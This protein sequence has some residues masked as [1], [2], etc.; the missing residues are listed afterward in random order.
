MVAGHDLRGILVALIV[1]GASVG[2]QLVTPSQRADASTAPHSALGRA[3]VWAE[4]DETFAKSAF[5]IKSYNWSGLVDTGSTFTSVSGAWIVPTVK[6]SQPEEAAGEWVG[7]G[8]TTYA[9]LIQAGT[10]QVSV[11]GTT[12]YEMWYEMLPD[13]PV[14]FATANPG[15]LISASVTNVGLN[16]WRIYITD[17]TSNVGIDEV[18]SYDTPAESAEWVIEAPTD[19]SGIVPFADFRS[20]TFFDLA[21]TGADLGQ[22]SVLATD[23]YDPD[24]GMLLA[25]STGLI[26]GDQ[27]TVDYV[28]QGYD[29]VGA[30]GQV[31]SYGYAPYLGSTFASGLDPEAAMAVDPTTG[32][33]WLVTSSGAVDAFG[34]NDYG[35]TAGI[36][37]NKPIVGMAA[38]PETGGYW[39]VASDGGIFA[40]NAPFFG[41]MGG[42]RLNQPIVG[43]TPTP[44]GGGYWL[45][46]SDGGIF[47]F[48]DAGFHGSM[49]GTRLNRP[50]VGMAV[51][52]Q[53]GG[54]WLVAS[55]GGIFAFDAPFS[56]SMGGGQLNQ[57]IVGMAATNDDGGYWFV[58][59][60]GG[61]FSFGDAQ[62]LGSLGGQPLPA[63]I[64][65]MAGAG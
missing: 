43:M 5:D 32:G 31:T 61:I 11:N 24:S 62:F 26:P 34:S 42:T 15:D 41:S 46:A 25:Q 29:V 37:L 33:Y 10:S 4:H 12:L 57:P 22:V 17:D 30:D 27:V 7:I 52:A 60:D 28:A 2:V 23:A 6:P 44:D 3:P 58:A 49:G 59:S 36:P 9:P 18:F 8:G 14:D 19:S 54:Y 50:V 48:G 45:V 40:F 53:T 1:C 38:D 51:D 21:V 39:L 65:G 16:S 63:P 64:V 13:N 55:D 47:A 35:S 20:I 56:G